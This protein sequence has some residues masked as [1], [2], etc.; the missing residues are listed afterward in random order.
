LPTVIG[1]WRTANWHER[2][3][4][5]MMGIRFRGHPDL[6]R[7]L[8]WEGYPYFPLRKDFPLAGKPSE[9]RA[10][11]FRN[12]RRSKAVRLCTAPVRRFRKDACIPETDAIE[13]WGGWNAA[14][15]QKRTAISGAGA[16]RK[17]NMPNF[18]TK[19]P[20]PPRALRRRRKSFRTLQGE[21][22]GS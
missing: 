17:N 3:I 20:I 1:V 22:H 4:Y 6:R 9:C 5:D 16:V 12:R 8:M 10:S 14:T 15:I 19:F 21:T 7:I 18:R 11:P 2:E 13:P